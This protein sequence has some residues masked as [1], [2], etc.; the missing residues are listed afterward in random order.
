MEAIKKMKFTL[1]DNLVNEVWGEVGT[2]ERDAME[3]QLKD[4]VDAY[5]VKEVIKQARKSKD[6]TRKKK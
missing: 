4:E 2:P 6:L 5:F 1:A 3:A